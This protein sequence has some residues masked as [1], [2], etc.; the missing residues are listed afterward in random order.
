MSCRSSC[1]FCLLLLLAASAQPLPPATASDAAPLVSFLL[2]RL[3]LAGDAFCHI[4]AL[5]RCALR[6]LMFCT[7][8]HEMH[9]PTRRATRGERPLIVS[10]LGLLLF[11]CVPAAWAPLAPEPGPYAGLLLV[12]VLIQELAR[13]GVWRFHRQDGSASLC[14][15]KLLPRCNLHSCICTLC[16]THLLSTPVQDEHAGAEPHGTRAARRAAQR[17]RQL[18]PGTVLWLLPRRR[19]LR[20]LVPLLAAAQPG[21][22]NNLQPTLPAPVLLHC[23]CPVHVGHGRCAHW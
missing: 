3:L 14:L 21:L 11:C 15:S 19:A 18:F 8:R 6:R 7:F 2:Q 20:I 9:M 16:C 13:V 23:G 10:H 5:Q 4:I 22:W 1:H 12:A 17:S